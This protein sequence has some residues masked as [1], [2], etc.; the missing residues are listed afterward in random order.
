MSLGE[1]EGSIIKHSKGIYFVEFA[2]KSFIV[3]D[4]KLLKWE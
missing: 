3:L 4:Y 2:F 1:K